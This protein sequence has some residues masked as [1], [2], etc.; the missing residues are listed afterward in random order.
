MLHVMFVLGVSIAGGMV[1]WVV[2]WIIEEIEE[3]LGARR[4]QR[5]DHAR[6]A[7]RQARAVR[8]IGWITT[9]AVAEL[10]QIAYEE[11]LYA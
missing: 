11:P 9:A 6:L 1:G 7:I 10:V 2:G 8:E 3:A 5:R 4:Q